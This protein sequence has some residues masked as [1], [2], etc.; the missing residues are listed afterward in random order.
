MF[1]TT[2]RSI[3][4]HAVPQ[5]GR[6]GWQV[7]L[8]A[9]LSVI[10]A[11]AAFALSFSAL[12]DLA[13]MTGVFPGPLPAL[14]PITIDVFMIQASFWLVLAAAAGDS[15]GRRTHWGVLALSSVVSIGLNCYHAWVASS[16]LLPAAVSAA[17]ASIPPLV[18]LAST[19]GLM[20]HLTQRS[21]PQPMSAPDAQPQVSDTPTV[22]T[23]EPVVH[24]VDNTLNSNL[25]P[26]QA[27]HTAAARQP[28]SKVVITDAHLAQARLVKSEGRLTKS[29]RDVARVLALRDAGY[30]PGEIEAALP[31]I[32]VRTTIARW[33]QRAD[34]LFAAALDADQD[35]SE[36]SESAART[37]EPAD[38]TLTT[39]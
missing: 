17:I 4:H 27:V 29:E 26:V 36:E 7:I 21:T 15:R 13:R 1:N 32:G 10:V 11:G 24:D 39:A 12:A 23:T 33:L 28:V 20:V 35:Q 22:A 34:E 14:L 30:T 6:L 9:S 25:D 8:A 2:Q 38:W 5:P 18:L 37:G 16:G 31:E 19:H 3:D